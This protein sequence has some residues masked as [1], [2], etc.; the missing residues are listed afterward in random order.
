MQSPDPGE[1]DS[2]APG[3]AQRQETHVPPIQTDSSPWGRLTVCPGKRQL[4]SETNLKRARKE[5]GMIILTRREG[6]FLRDTV[7]IVGDV[8][9]VELQGHS[10][11]VPTPQEVHAHAEVLREVTGHA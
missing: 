2:G 9:D 10:R 11:P 5:A 6:V 4:R 1:R 8:L 3:K 7:N